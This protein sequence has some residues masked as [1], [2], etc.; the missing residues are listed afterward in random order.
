MRFSQSISAYFILSQSILALTEYVKLCIFKLM[1]ATDKGL[2]D[3]NMVLQANFNLTLI[4][5]FDSKYYK[6][7][8][9]CEA[10]DLCL[11]K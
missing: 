3:L 6:A 10:L 1:H 11:S 4:D 9:S 5:S 7:D 8:K 2:N